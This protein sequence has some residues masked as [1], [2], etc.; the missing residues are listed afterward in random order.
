MGQTLMAQC[1]CGFNQK[2]RFGSGRFDCAYISNLPC[3]CQACKSMATLNVL[4]EKLIC[5]NCNSENILPYNHREMFKGEVVADKNESS[6]QS[7]P[8]NRTTYTLEGLA[9]I[10][11]LI[12]DEGWSI[13][14]IN[15]R[16]ELSRFLDDI[17]QSKKIVCDDLNQ[18]IMD[19]RCPKCEKFTLFFTTIDYY[20]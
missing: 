20:D 13:F 6:S 3:Y 5:P 14:S 2:V 19:Y 8:R 12:E 15:R 7:D 9:S 11:K 16:D 1:A 17:S 10:E 18:N 4:S